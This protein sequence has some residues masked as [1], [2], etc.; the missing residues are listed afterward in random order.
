V[1]IGLSLFA[2]AL[3]AVLRFAVTVHPGGIDI[4]T[5]GII[6]MVVGSIGLIICLWLTVSGRASTDTG[7]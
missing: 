1:T 7:V 2:I 3:G 4:A 5:V 6:L